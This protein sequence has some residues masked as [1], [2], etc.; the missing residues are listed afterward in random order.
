MVSVVIPVK[1]GARY[2]A[3]VLA[4]V[5]AQAPDAEVLVIDSG[6]HDDSVAI[7]RAAGARVHEIAPS[8]FGHGRTRNLGAE[9][10]TGDPICFLTQDA[11]P[12]PGWLAALTAPFAAD[13]HVGVVFGP[14]LPRRDTPPMVARELAQFFARLGADDPYL[15][16]VNAAYRRAC[17]EELR[18]R[19]VAYAEDQAFGRALAATGWRKVF[20][21]D[22]A[23]HHAHDYGVLGFMRRAFDEA[24]GLRETTGWVETISPRAT[25]GGIRRLV[26][27]DV[28]W[29][30]EQQVPALQ[31]ARWTL[32]SVVHHTSRKPL[33]W[34][35]SRADRLPRP[36]RRALSLERRAD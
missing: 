19:D 30:R 5:A 9:L 27:R 33:A 10:T 24:R 1:D 17:W 25:A 22:A 31:R 3:E 35:G 7:A 23:V 21:A 26:G 36:L 16:N 4:A 13:E 18:F 20:A 15:S 12:A 11:T 2:L 28:R 8:E 32:R 6:S 14:Q 34:L 29:M